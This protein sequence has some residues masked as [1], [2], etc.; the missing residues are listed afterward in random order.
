M[1]YVCN[2]KFFRSF[3]KKEKEIGEIDFDNCLI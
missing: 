2:L 1:S 3:N